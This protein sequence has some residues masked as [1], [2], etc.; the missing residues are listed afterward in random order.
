VGASL[1]EALGSPS[2]APAPNLTASLL[3]SNEAISEADETDD[4]EGEEESRAR[5]GDDAKAAVDS[6]A[7]VESKATPAKSDIRK[8]FEAV[9]KAREMIDA[10]EA[11]GSYGTQDN[12]EDEDQAGQLATPPP[13][14]TKPRVKSQTVYP[15][16]YPLKVQVDKGE[17]EAEKERIKMEVRRELACFY[18]FHFVP[19]NTVRSLLRSSLRSPQLERKDRER[20]RENRMNIIFSQ[21]Q[22]MKA[23]VQSARGDIKT[24]ATID[25][26]ETK[27]ITSYCAAL[28]SLQTQHTLLHDLKAATRGHQVELRKVRSDEDTK[29]P[30]CGTSPRAPLCFA[31]FSTL[32]PCRSLMQFQKSLKT[33]KNIVKGRMMEMEG[34]ED[35]A[36]GGKN[37]PRTAAKTNGTKKKK[38]TER[39]TVGQVSPPP[40]PTLVAGIDKH[41]AV[42][43]TNGA[44]QSQPPKFSIRYSQT[45]ATA[46]RDTFTNSHSLNPKRATMKELTAGTVRVSS[47]VT[48]AS[49]PP[50][51]PKRLGM[52]RSYDHTGEVKSVRRVSFTLR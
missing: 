42:L 49:L 38:E 6:K 21:Q 43:E 28:E 33:E 23:M 11:G 35:A 48:A 36:Q 12:D 24:T 52:D 39:S 18:R 17:V 26:L 8:S 13:P 41:E 27:L 4:E 51:P 16:S 40:P 45:Q 50:P 19:S 47:P 34:G 30:P 46:R 3:P 22:R 37:T 31:H 5:G 32:L 10:S 1:S 44:G 25:S 29:Q 20:E 9:V 2:P 15:S 14:V 7:A